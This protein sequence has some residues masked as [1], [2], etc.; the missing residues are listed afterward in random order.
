MGCFL[1]VFI[2]KSDTI[3]YLFFGW[4][5]T[6]INIYW[7]AHS[8]T[9]HLLQQRNRRRHLWTAST[10]LCVNQDKCHDIWLRLDQGFSIS[11]A[12]RLSGSIAFSS[13]ILN[14]QASR[15]LVG[16]LSAEAPLDSEPASQ[17]AAIVPADGAGSVNKMPDCSQWDTPHSTLFTLFPQFKLF[18]MFAFFF[19]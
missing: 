2:S 5:W 17:S 12:G 6:D 18:F 7:R 8:R 11:K 9:H 1:S 13:V 16:Q 3:W 14:Q 19:K 10:A 4:Y 15:N